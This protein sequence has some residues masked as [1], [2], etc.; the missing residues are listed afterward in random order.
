MGSEMCIRDSEQEARDFSKGMVASDRKRSGERLGARVSFSSQPST[1]T[2]DS[3]ATEK[4]DAGV[5]GKNKDGHTIR[6]NKIPASSKRL[7]TS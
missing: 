7:Q 2:S 4:R 5:Y 1:L 3:I 6:K